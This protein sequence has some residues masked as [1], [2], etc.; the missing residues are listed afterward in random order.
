[1]GC[2]GGGGQ[3]RRFVKMSE[4]NHRPFKQTMAAS[5]SVIRRL[6]PWMSSMDDDMSPSMD[7]I[8]PSMDDTSPSMEDFQGWHF[9]P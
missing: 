1:M 6:H 3:R 5:M 4:I 2:G 9:Y 7:D 8:S